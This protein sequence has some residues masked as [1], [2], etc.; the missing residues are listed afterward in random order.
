MSTLKIAQPDAQ[1][2]GVW[3]DL[4]AMVDA[5]ASEDQIHGLFKYDEAGW[6]YQ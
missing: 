4:S 3:L 1:Y 2:E 6:R 5:E